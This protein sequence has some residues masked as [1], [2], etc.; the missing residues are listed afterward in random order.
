M[1]KVYLKF[2]NEKEKEKEPISNQ[3]R[4]SEVENTFKRSAKIVADVLSFTEENNFNAK[5]I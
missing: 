1:K 5:R 3:K 4:A 2:K